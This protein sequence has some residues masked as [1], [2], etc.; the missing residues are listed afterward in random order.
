MSESRH[1]KEEREG[2]T[3]HACTVDEFRLVGDIHR[4]CFIQEACVDDG[5][6]CVFG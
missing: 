4:F 3:N 6:V 2:D 5:N 1:M